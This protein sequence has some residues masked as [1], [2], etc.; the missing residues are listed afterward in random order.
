MRPENYMNLLV[1][2]CWCSTQ[3]SA[4]LLCSYFFVF[5]KRKSS[6]F[7]LESNVLSKT[8]SIFNSLIFFQNEFAYEGQIYY[9]LSVSYVI[10]LGYLVC[11][12]VCLCVCVCVCVYFF[13]EVVYNN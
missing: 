8:R 1:A 12:S 5:Q 6:F 10:H 7:F 11:L 13:Q 2:S 9:I 3:D 4:E